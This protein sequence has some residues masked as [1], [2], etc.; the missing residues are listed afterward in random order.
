MVF[1]PSL[2]DMMVVM[3]EITMQASTFKAQCLAVLD[4][5]AHSH[6]SVVITKH[7]KAVARLVPIESDEQSIFGSVTFLSE[8]ESDYFSTGE[9]WNAES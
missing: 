4:D 3:D 5:V 6:R 1:L 8:D 7:G 2:S 9:T